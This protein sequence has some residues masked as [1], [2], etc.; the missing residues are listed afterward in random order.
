MTGFEETFLMAT[1]F[2]VV[3]ILAGL[4]VPGRRPI[5]API[6]LEAQLEAQ[7]AANPD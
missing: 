2:L 1:G 3:C 7:L 6:K 4:L 5:P